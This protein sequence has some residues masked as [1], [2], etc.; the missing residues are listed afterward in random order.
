MARAIL[1]IGLCAGPAATTAAAAADTGTIRGTVVETAGGAAI[2]D[3]S[4]RLQSSGYAVVTDDEGR[5]EFR[6]AFPNPG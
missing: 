6:D 2:R 3:V 5:F 4:V 1:W